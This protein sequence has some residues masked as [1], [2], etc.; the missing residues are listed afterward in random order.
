MEKKHLFSLKYSI[1]SSSSIIPLMDDGIPV[2][3]LHFD[4]YIVAVEAPD[5]CMM[6][7][8]RNTVNTYFKALENNVLR[9]QVDAMLCSAIA[10]NVLAKQKSIYNY[11]KKHCNS[12]SMTSVFAVFLIL[13]PIGVSYLKPTTATELLLKI[14]S[15][16]QLLI[17]NLYWWPVPSID[18]VAAIRY[19]GTNG[20]DHLQEECVKAV[21]CVIT[22]VNKLSTIDKDMAKEMDKPNLHRALELCHHSLFVYSHTRNFAEMS[23]EVVH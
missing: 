19:H 1:L 4:P 17:R 18:G 21:E 14:M 9:R 8:I 12:M 2:S 3:S 13:E 5:H 7:I 10:E 6:G 23:L 16:L 20:A 11:Q 15:E 22:L